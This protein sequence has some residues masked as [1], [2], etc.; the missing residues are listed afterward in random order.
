M[1]NINQIQVGSIVYDIEDQVA[2]NSIPSI[3]KPV[4][5]AAAN[6][7]GSGPYTNTVTVNGLLA[8]D[9][10]I[11]DL[12]PSS[13]YA[14]AQEEVADYSTVYKAVCATNNTLTLYAN[15]APGHNF[16]VQLICVR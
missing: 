10:I 4:L 14:T 7:T 3:V 15:G 16:N 8:T 13:T 12:M 2:R 9:T 5:I 1:A 6:W 11:M